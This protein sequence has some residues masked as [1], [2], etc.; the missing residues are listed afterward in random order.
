MNSTHR[1]V[2]WYW[3]HVVHEM[4]QE[5]YFESHCC[6]ALIGLSCLICE[7]LLALM[8]SVQKF[9]KVE[10]SWCLLLLSSVNCKSQCLLYV[11]E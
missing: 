2:K 3:E 1:L 7:R 5:E 8:G 10:T 9:I 6:L 4:C 11:G